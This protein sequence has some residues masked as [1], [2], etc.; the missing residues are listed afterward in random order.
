[1]GSHQRQDCQKGGRGD[2]LAGLADSAGLLNQPALTPHLHLFE[3]KH[4]H[5]HVTY[6]VLSFLPIA[7]ESN[8]PDEMTKRANN[9]FSLKRK[10]PIKHH[11][12]LHLFLILELF[13]Q[14]AWI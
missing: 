13:N 1:M 3:N 10:F 9:L 14:E 5:F 12:S 4:T 11:S 7:A 6:R 2:F 8:L